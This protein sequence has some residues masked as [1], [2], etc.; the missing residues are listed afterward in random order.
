[1]DGGLARKVE[2]LDR[3]RGVSEIEALYLPASALA[4]KQA[5][6]VALSESQ[7]L[8]YVSDGVKAGNAVVY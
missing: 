2:R 3:G 5:I 4:D 1:M 8:G 7:S 6:R